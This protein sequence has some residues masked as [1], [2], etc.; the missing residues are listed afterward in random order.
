MCSVREF[1]CSSPFPFGTNINEESN[2]N[3]TLPLNP[4]CFQE[5]QRELFVQDDFYLLR[6]QCYGI[7]GGIVNEGKKSV[8]K[9]IVPI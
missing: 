6:F 7:F 1:L 2:N 9:V 4:S 5:L 8:I 3:Y